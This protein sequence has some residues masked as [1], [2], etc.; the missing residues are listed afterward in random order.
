MQIIIL[1]FI[2]GFLIYIGNGIR[3]AFRN[4]PEFFIPIS[5]AL[6]ITFL[7]LIGYCLFWI[8]SFGVLI[9]GFIYLI[10]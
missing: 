6:G 5:K 10:K 8:L 1:L 4:N 9:A 3:K 7:A 2:V